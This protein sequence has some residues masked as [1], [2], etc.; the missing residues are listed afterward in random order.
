MTD[1]FAS[2]IAT[3]SGTRAMVLEKSLDIA[4]GA[5]AVVAVARD[6]KRGDIGSSRIE[7][8][9]P[10][11]AKSVAAIAPIA[12]LQTSPA[13]MSTDGAASS[14]GSLARDVDELIDPSASVTLASGRL[15]RREDEESGHRR[16]LVRRRL[17]R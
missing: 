4:P 13:A 1:H 6:A 3:K 17:A 9:W 14:L 11:P 16:A 10:N 2:S 8:D 7:A 5:F 12:V 15:P